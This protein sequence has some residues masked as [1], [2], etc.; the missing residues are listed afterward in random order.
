MVRLR[1]CGI[2][3]SAIGGGGVRS[4]GGVGRSL[5]TKSYKGSFSSG[6]SGSGK[7]SGG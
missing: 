2:F 3:N 5:P 6:K 4:D 1:L 7:A